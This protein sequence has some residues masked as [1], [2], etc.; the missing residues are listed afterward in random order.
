MANHTFPRL[1]S[2][3]TNFVTELDARLD[4]LAVGL[5][6]AVTTVT[7]PPPNSIRWSSAINRWQKWNGSAWVDLTAGYTI[8]ISGASVAATTLTTSGNATLG[9]STSADSHTINGA[10]GITADSTSPALRITQAGTGNALVVED[11]SSD[12][13]PFVIDQNGI[14]VRGYSA[15][16]LAAN[17]LGVNGTHAM[18]VHG[19]TASLLALANWN[20][21]AGSAAGL[22]LL[23]SKSNSVD[24]HTTVTNNDH[25]GAIGFAGSDGTAFAVAA[26][27]VAEVD[28]TVA[29]GSVPGRIVFST[30]AAGATLPVERMRIRADGTV[31][32]AGAT[33]RDAVVV[34]YTSS[35]TWNPA[36]Y[37][38]YKAVQ[39]I[40]AGGGGGGGGGARVA[41]GT[42]CSGGGGGGGGALVSVLMT[43]AE[44]TGTATITVGAGGN[45][46]TGATTAGTAG[47][48][49]SAGNLTFVEI[50]GA[51]R[52][53]AR[54]GG[55]GAGGQVSDNSGGGGGS[56]HSGG[57]GSST[58]ATAGAAGGTGGVAGGSGST[59]PT[60][61]DN[62]N[63]MGSP[64]GGGGGGLNGGVGG[65]GGY[66][67]SGGQGG[68]GGGGV[69]TGGTA[70]AGGLGRFPLAT[71]SAGA[72]STVAAGTVG[73]GAGG[74]GSAEFAVAGSSGGGGG[75]N[76][77]GAG[78][79]GGVGSR[80]SGGGGGGSAI[81]GNG[82][83]GGKGGDGFVRVV[84]FF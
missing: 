76:G 84:V 49:G 71:R 10:T 65:A 68:G 27:V 50:G 80:G 5:D 77:A 44:I 6:P 51:R 23:K 55:G 13:T 52:V 16:I 30:T 58:G 34:D 29:T 20:N 72:G 33:N 73:G 62:G 53:F 57:G 75:A 54:E 17:Y 48:N 79:A 4:D 19:L 12:T 26:S 3:Y 69:N 39:W 32:F 36:N 40:V 2:T 66:A 7:N 70:F 59:A 78:G 18:Q 56:G 64:G 41:S 28:G 47:G 25:L 9:D 37:P 63:G 21:A 15:S 11:A 67:V 22:T 24:T 61:N 31:V 8:P 35:G 83:A 14:V 74:A 38:G 82:G 81:G 43:A 60:W 45:G 1:T 42:A 46:G